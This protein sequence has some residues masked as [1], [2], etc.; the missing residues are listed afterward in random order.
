MPDQVL[1]EAELA[2]DG[3]RLVGRPRQ[4]RPQVAVATGPS[5]GITVCRPSLP[6]ASWIITSTLSFVTF[7]CFAAY[8]AR[9]K[10]SG[11][12]A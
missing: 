10:T 6:P 9:A 3:Q 8:I 7:S 4:L 2:R 12:A 1:V 11:T 5:S